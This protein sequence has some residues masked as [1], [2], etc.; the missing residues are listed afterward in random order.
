[1]I[2]SLSFIFLIW[3]EDVFLMRSDE[4]Y[5][6]VENIVFFRIVIEEVGM[7]CPIFFLSFATYPMPL[8]ES[9]YFPFS[10]ASSFKISD[11]LTSNKFLKS[12]RVIY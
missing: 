7:S 3:Q 6:F 5:C 8:R 4:N 10:I 11:L 12:Y 1:L 9:L 2:P